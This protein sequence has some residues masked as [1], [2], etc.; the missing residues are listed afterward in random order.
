MLSLKNKNKKIHEIE[1]NIQMLYRSLA[2]ATIL[3][4]NPECK[5]RTITALSYC[6]EMASI[7]K[8]IHM[9]YQYEVGVIVG[10]DQYLL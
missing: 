8:H 3:I 5:K 9:H 6:K 1:H 7:R 10:R 4:I 2:T